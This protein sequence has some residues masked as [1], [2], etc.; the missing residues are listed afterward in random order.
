MTRLL[1]N[2]VDEKKL[3]IVYFLLK[4]GRADP[5]NDNSCIVE[6]ILRVKDA[7]KD[8]FLLFE[9]VKLV[10]SDARIDVASNV[11]LAFRAIAKMQCDAKMRNELYKMFLLHRKFANAR[12]HFVDVRHFDV[13]YFSHIL[14]CNSIV[15]SGRKYQLQVQGHWKR[16]FKQ[17]ISYVLSDAKALCIGFKSLGL[18]VLL[19]I[20]LIE[21]LTEPFAN[22]QNLALLWKICQII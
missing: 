13:E 22:L 1:D 21:S 3:Q 10:L 7:I 9:T 12:F 17:R 6:E 11:K 16:I 8:K 15:E 4:D 5:S 14:A 20:E 19:T 18:P 2:A